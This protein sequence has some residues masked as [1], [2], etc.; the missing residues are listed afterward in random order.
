M[1]SIR[2]VLGLTFDGRPIFEPNTSASSLCFA[3][4]GGWKTTAVSVPA[5]QAMLADRRRALFINDVKNGEI[6][7][8]IGPMCLKYG[9]RFG[10]VDDFEVLGP[11][12]AHRLRLNPF[13]SI[14]A[15]HQRRDR[16]LPFLI[17]TMTHTLI[18]EVGG[19]EKNRYWREEPRALL[20]LGARILLER[21]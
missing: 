6:A 4:T 19:D 17:E 5:V 11:E 18:P 13:S 14:V 8:Q 10:V 7:A 2:R 3:A 15:A 21:S 9:R 16:D 12:Y 1:T 20:D